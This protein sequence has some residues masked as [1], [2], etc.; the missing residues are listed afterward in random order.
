MSTTVW[1]LEMTAPEELDP[2]P[3]PRENVEAR[4][5]EIPLGTLN[6]FF[7]RAVGGPWKWT[8]RL[9]WSP[10]EWQ[11]RTEAPNVRL[12]LLYEAGTPAGYCE[13]EVTPEGGGEIVYFGL[14]PQFT[15]RGLGKYFLTECVRRVWDLVDEAGEGTKRRVWL[16]TCTD[17][18]PHA[19]RNYEARGF[20]LYRTEL[21]KE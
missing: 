13:M 6:E 10:E 14:L 16:H 18:S 1:Y 5:A 21:E 8:D 19:K 15:G 7:Y 4:R 3:A 20:R 17:D 12:W 2:A 11:R 9:V